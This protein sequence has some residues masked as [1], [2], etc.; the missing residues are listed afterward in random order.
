MCECAIVRSPG[1]CPA[2]RDTTS[3]SL[4]GRSSAA[5]QGYRRSGSPGYRDRSSWSATAG[6]SFSEAD[7]ASGVLNTSRQ[8]GGS[9]GLA[10]LATI[11]TGQTP[12]MLTGTAGSQGRRGPSAVGASGKAIADRRVALQEVAVLIT[13]LASDAVGVHLQVVDL[14]RVSLAPH[15]L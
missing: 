8:I 4:D 5:Q 10:V 15:V 3:R 13:E 14:V 6:A 7:L 12:A 2:G 9:L 11:A 1:C